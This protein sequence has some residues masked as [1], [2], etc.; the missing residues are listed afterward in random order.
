M[1]YTFRKGFDDIARCFARYHGMTVEETKEN[2]EKVGIIPLLKKHYVGIAYETALR[3]VAFMRREISKLDQPL[4]TQLYFQAVLD[5]NV[6]PK[7]ADDSSS[8]YTYDD[9]L[10]D[11][12]ECFAAYHGMGIKE[13]EEYFE[14]VGLIPFIERYYE[15]LSLEH[16]LE[17]IRLV[18]KEICKLGQPLP[19]Q[20][21]F[22]TLYNIDV[23]S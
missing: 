12:A 8:A 13:T 17:L 21:Y 19:T 5:D 16:D 3:L 18:R 7:T 9:A 6:L 4:P 14:K 2:F 11:I 23:P 20:L 10:E 15:G 22:K 1:P